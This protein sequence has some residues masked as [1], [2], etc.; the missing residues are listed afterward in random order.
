MVKEI[1]EDYSEVFI[2]DMYRETEQK[3]FELVPL[4]SA[5]PLMDVAEKF[6]VMHG[7]YPTDIFNKIWKEHSFFLR[8]SYLLIDDIKA[9]IWEPTFSKCNELLNSIRDG[10]IKLSDVDLYMKPLDENI[11]TQ[12]KRL[13]NGVGKCVNI[14][15]RENSG[16]IDA[17]VK[18]MN[19]YWSLS[20]VAEAAKTVIHFKDSLSLTG[21]F[22]LIEKLA[23]RVSLY[24]SI[25]AIIIIKVMLWA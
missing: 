23:S 17:A 16:W 19:E 5:L 14:G 18:L 10:S 1:N 13:C 8:D 20:D 2:K 12:L 11:A 15:D 6:D 3:T 22:S 4:Q 7:D 21:D 9:K 24:E 25:L